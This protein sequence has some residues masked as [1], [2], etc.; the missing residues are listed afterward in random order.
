LL[1]SCMRGNDEL[2]LISC[3]HQDDGHSLGSIASLSSPPRL[4]PP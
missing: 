1:D 4:V 3:M 2:L